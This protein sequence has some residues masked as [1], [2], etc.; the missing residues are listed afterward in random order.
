M[1]VKTSE[2]QEL[3]DAFKKDAV[4]L[5]IPLNTNRTNSQLN[6]Q[7]TNKSNNNR[8][9]YG[10]KS[11]E[12]CCLAL[13]ELHVKLQSNPLTG[14]LSAEEQCLVKYIPLFSSG[15]FDNLVNTLTTKGYTDTSENSLW[16]MTALILAQHSNAE[17][18]HTKPQEFANLANTWLEA[19]LI[20]N[21]R[22]IPEIPPTY[23]NPHN[24]FFYSTD[25]NLDY[26]QVYAK[27]LLMISQQFSRMLPTDKWN[28]KVIAF[29]AI[30]K[31]LPGVIADH[32]FITSSRFSNAITR[33]EG[34]VT[35]APSA[36]APAADEPP[37]AYSE[38]ADAAPAYEPP[39]TGASLAAAA[40]AVLPVYLTPE[41]QAMQQAG[42][43]LMKAGLANL[44][45]AFGTDT[46]TLPQA[47]A[48]AP[49]PSAAER[50]AIEELTRSMLGLFSG[51]P[52]PSDDND[53]DEPTNQSNNECC[54]Q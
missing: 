44:A 11:L 25:R 31:I 50:A 10:G 51:R 35:A 7:A 49:P 45:T 2:V 27:Q 54:I 43:D 30:M 21:C 41:Q 36:A 20:C 9:I 48:S 46:T 34:L 17:S 18:F 3:I 40:E 6:N 1:P 12:A 15:C 33:L 37:P 13:K 14:E 28:L 42:Q 22:Y 47:A 23:P 29:N 24:N 16:A 8:S 26:F 52:A 5:R 53:D 38:H 39:S 4:V 19:L 32:N